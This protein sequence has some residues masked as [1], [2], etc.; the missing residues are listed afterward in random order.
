MI[1]LMEMLTDFTYDG[2]AFTCSVNNFGLILDHCVSDTVNR[3]NYFDLT[4]C[5][6]C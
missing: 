6:V 3:A 1:I 2:D 4:R 5:R